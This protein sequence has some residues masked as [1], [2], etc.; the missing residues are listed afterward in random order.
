M[1]AAVPEGH[2]LAKL[3][4][5]PRAELLKEPF[6]EAPRNINP[7]LT[8][9]LHQTLFGD[10]PHPQRVEVPLVEEARRL[11]LIAEG[12]GVGVTVTH[13]GLERPGVVFR[14]L[15]E[16]TQPLRYGVAWP[17]IQA[18][19][20]LDSFIELAREIAATDEDPSSVA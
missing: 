13:L 9:Y 3:E 12:K 11:E 7:E 17:A 15:D 18:S 1:V 5:V 2:R 16:G 6:I 10:T 4:R 8:D 14:P 19:P 20:F